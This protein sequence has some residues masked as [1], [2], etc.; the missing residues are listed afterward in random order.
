MLY[1]LGGEGCGADQYQV[2]LVLPLAFLKLERTSCD[3]GGKISSQAFIQ[4]YFEYKVGALALVLGF[5][6]PF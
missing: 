5:A 4:S 1:Y 2:D 3:L 6:L